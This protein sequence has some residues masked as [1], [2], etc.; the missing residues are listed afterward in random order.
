MTR[1][2]HGELQHPVEVTPGVTVTWDPAHPHRCV[3]VTVDHGD[4]GA[5]VQGVDRA[6]WLRLAAVAVLD[7]RLYLPLDRD[8]LDAEL[9]AAQLAAARTLDAAEPAREVLTGRALVGARR[10]SRGVVAQ[11]ERFVA[12]DRRPPPALGSSLSTLVRCYAALSGEVRGFD[13]ALAGVTGMWRRLGTVDRSPLRGRRVVPPTPVEPVHDGTAQIDPRSVPARVLRLGPTVDAAEIAVD[14][15]RGEDGAAVRVRVDAFPAASRGDVGVRLVDRRS[16][17][18]RG[19]G[20]LGSPPGE[21]GYQGVVALP[22]SLTAADVRVD[23]FGTAADP[24]GP[25]ACEELRRVRR[26]T[27]FLSGW[28]AL[29]ADVR[30]W[31]VR[32]APVERLRAMARQLAD[33]ADGPLWSRGPTPS[34]L[35]LLTELGDWAL[36]GLVRRGSARPVTIAGDHGGAAAVLAAVA[37]PGDLL[38]AEL[39]AAHERSR[40]G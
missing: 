36:A 32:A 20:V 25:A 27:L 21:H 6:Q 37:G 14:P 15:V 19:Y 17:E 5:R 40:R 35:R 12:E 29:V 28:R 38:A 31:G 18:I 4:A 22:A 26:A 39:A 16:G 8:L 13:G 7:H 24:P 34:H 9:A 33:D 1:T 3:D 11:L 23:V 2:R 30:L 10:A